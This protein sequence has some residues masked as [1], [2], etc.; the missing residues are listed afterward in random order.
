MNLAVNSGAT[1]IWVVNVGDLKPMEFPI[2]FFLTMA[3]HAD[4]WNQDNLQDYTRRWAAR[5]FGPEHADE[6]ASLITTY[7]KYNG[8]RKPE[9]LEPDTFSLIHFH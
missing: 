5:D 2:E 1:R 9:Q 7:T 4:L 8:R 3:R 6:I